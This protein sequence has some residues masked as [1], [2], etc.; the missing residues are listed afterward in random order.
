METP[1]HFL[2]HELLKL[3]AV[4]ERA[5]LKVEIAII[6]QQRQSFGFCDIML[7]IVKS[8][9][10][11]KGFL[12]LWLQPG[13][14]VYPPLTLLLLNSRSNDK[15]QPEDDGEGKEYEKDI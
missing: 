1:E 13:K 2:V 3:F 11:R 12:Y 8:C 10:L 7:E 4:K 14:C 5:N 6:F 15:H 9:N